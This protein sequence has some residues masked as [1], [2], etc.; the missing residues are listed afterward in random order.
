MA[1][2]L[3]G[4]FTGMTEFNQF[5]ASDSEY[6]NGNPSRRLSAMFLLFA[7]FASWSA[8]LNDHGRRTI[9]SKT[10]FIVLKTWSNIIQQRKTGEKYLRF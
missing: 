10:I 6:G 7:I 4:S 3:G 8:S 1:K 9:P 2:N 5:C